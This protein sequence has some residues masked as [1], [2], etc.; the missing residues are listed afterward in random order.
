MTGVVRNNVEPLST[1]IEEEE[2]QEHILKKGGAR[3]EN[4]CDKNSK[5]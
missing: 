3:Q 5:H 1:S 4:E 2:Y